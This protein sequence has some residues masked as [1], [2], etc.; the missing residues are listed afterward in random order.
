MSTEEKK[1]WHKQ[2]S[3]MMKRADRQ[4]QLD[5]ACELICTIRPIETEILIALERKFFIG[6]K[7]AQSIYDEA[8]KYEEDNADCLGVD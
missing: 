3:A 7:T 1:A 4:G 8:Y 6:R 5:L 2:C